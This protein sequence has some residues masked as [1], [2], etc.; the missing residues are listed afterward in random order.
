MYSISIEGGCVV[1]FF[2]K[3]N[4]GTGNDWIDPIYWD[5]AGCRGALSGGL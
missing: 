3:M 4:C 5:N 2:E 1:L